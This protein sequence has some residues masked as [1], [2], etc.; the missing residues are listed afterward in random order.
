MP[1][2]TR[3]RQQPDYG[4]DLLAAR[5]AQAKGPV[6][7]KRLPD[8][9]RSDFEARS[10]Y[11]ARNLRV[12]ES[13]LPSAADAY[14]VTQGSTIHFPRGGFAPGTSEGRETL[15][16]ELA[17]TV[18]QAQGKVRAN[19]AGV[20]NDSP[21]LEQAADTAFAGPASTGDSSVEAASL[22]SMPTPSAGAPMQLR[23][24]LQRIRDHFR[25]TRAT[26][27]APTTAPA[28][29]DPSIAIGTTFTP[30]SP[31]PAPTGSGGN[32][33]ST[34]GNQSGGQGNNQSGGQSSGP[35]NTSAG[36]TPTGSNASNGPS[37]GGP[38]NT[39]AGNTPAPASAGGA[40]S[41]SPTT[42]SGGTTTARRVFDQDLL[43]EI[44]PTGNFTE[45]KLEQGM[46]RRERGRRQRKVAH[47]QRKTEKRAFYDEVRQKDQ[48]FAY[49]TGKMKTL[50]EEIRANNPNVP[51]L[52]PQVRAAKERLRA[53]KIQELYQFREQEEA[54]HLNWL[55]S[56]FR[57]NSSMPRGERNE[58]RERI[59]K[60]V[61]HNQKKDLK[62]YLSG[63]AL[64]RYL[65]NYDGR[66]YNEGR[67][68]FVGGS[69]ATAPAA[70]AAASGTATSGAP[71][72]APAATPAPAAAAAANGAAPVPPAVAA[73]QAA[74][75]AARPQAAAAT[76]TS[77][78][79]R[80]ASPL[81]SRAVEPKS[82]GVMD[83]I[84]TGFGLLD[85]YGGMAIGS[86]GEVEGIRKG[87]TSVKEHTG[88][89]QFVNGGWGTGLNHAL[90]MAGLVSDGYNLVQSFQDA[91]QAEKMGDAG[92]STQKQ[93]EG[94]GNFFNIGGRFNGFVPDS[95]DPVSATLAM[96][97]NV[98]GVASNSVAVNSARKIKHAMQDQ[99]TAMPAGMN[100]ADQ[101]QV[102]QYRMRREAELAAKRN[103]V[104]SGFGVANNVVGGLGNAAGLAVGPGTII[105]IASMGI[106]G[107]GTLAQMIT[108]KALDVHH[109]H[110][111]MD[112]MLQSDDM[113]QTLM[114]SGAM[115]LNQRDIRKVL[116][117]ASGSVDSQD[118][119]NRM[120]AI[121]ATELHQ[122]I[123]STTDIT[124]LDPDTKKYLHGLG[125]EDETKFKNITVDA[126]YAKMGGQGSWQRALV[127]GKALRR[128]EKA[129]EN[130]VKKQRFRNIYTAQQI[131]GS[132]GGG[133]SGNGPSG[134]GGNP[135]PNTP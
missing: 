46:G 67:H 109:R 116:A 63:S 70:N 65:Q 21:A 96:V 77:S 126:L 41:A 122:K 66:T 69:A 19:R 97:G 62:A 40:G 134:S 61:R 80:S 5:I 30:P 98:I 20:V 16:H 43:E 133:P 28:N 58:L 6:T 45:E 44:D 9:V 32:N 60:A 117:S 71:A 3:Q 121:D 74:W 25:R 24:P 38:A 78:A 118:M 115:G 92:L 15:M 73:T 72:P 101:G 53:Q 42:A 59:D 131:A 55:Y 56:Q 130:A 27:T 104:S 86:D 123:Q 89:E 1:E 99:M 52:S 7:E 48:G 94:V 17:H 128:Q 2:Y 36:N 82:H 83:K 10:G 33:T 75:L 79:P 11:S 111:L 108:D 8:D 29:A 51:G 135:P 57:A 103:H 39:S 95:P 76:R 88:Y 102:Q 14:A 106:T 35:A 12:V 113:L 49:D 13:D 129:Q 125:Y 85:Q 91:Y 81:G 4:D 34:G 54:R 127:G 22:A 68:A 47:E 84:Q 114:Q 132:Q 110:V 119:R 105:K 37:T 18:Q 87:F 124:T 93:I 64:V 112:E 26:G 90:G 100:T 31:S 23:S 50:M 120:A 107:L